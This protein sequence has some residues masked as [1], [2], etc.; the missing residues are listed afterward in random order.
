V[1]KYIKEHYGVPA[2]IGR[3]IKVDG[4][5]GIIA[6]DRGNYLGVNFDSDSP[7]VIRNVHPT[8]QVEYMGMG[9]IRRSKKKEQDNIVLENDQ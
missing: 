6:E 2:D 3:R 4:Q 5:A 8:W 7:G 9:V 1:C